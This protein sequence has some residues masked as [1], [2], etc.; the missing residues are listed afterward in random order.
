[1]APSV[2]QPFLNQMKIIV[3]E[4]VPHLT[5]NF[6]FDSKMVEGQMAPLL[7]QKLAI[8]WLAVIFKGLFENSC[9]RNGA[10]NLSVTN[11][12]W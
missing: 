7:L 3:G 2:H 10:R 11:I 5:T 4:I 6:S 8:V 1:M 9:G 12:F